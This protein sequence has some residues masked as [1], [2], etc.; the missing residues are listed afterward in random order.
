MLQKSLTTSLFVRLRICYSFFSPTLHSVNLGSPSRVRLQLCPLLTFTTDGWHAR[1]T[2]K[3]RPKPERLSPHSFQFWIRYERA[4][5]NCRLCCTFEVCADTFRAWPARHEYGVRIYSHP[6]PLWPALP[7][8]GWSAPGDLWR[9][10]VPYFYWFQTSLPSAALS[11]YGLWCNWRSPPP[12]L[13]YIPSRFAPSECFLH[14][15][16][17]DF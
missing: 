17:T 3:S 5:L 12:A 11:H 15:M 4:R 10:Y 2:T 16:R 1:H 8:S 6:E 14:L 13:Q 7:G 9:P